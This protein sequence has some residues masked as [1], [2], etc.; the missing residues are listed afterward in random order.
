M[1][2]LRVLQAEGIDCEPSLLGCYIS[3]NSVLQDIITP[4]T[5]DHC[6][7]IPHEGTI[8]ITM[9]TM[10]EDS[11]IIGSVVFPL[12]ILTHEQFWLPLSGD[13]PLAFLAEMPDLPRIQ[14]CI[15]SYEHS[16]ELSP[17]SNTITVS[18]EENDWPRLR[19]QLKM[20]SFSLQ[21]ITAELRATKDTLKSEHSTRQVLEH[22]LHETQSE[23]SQ[24]V[25]QA[26]GREKSMLRL[27]EQK[28][29]EIAENINQTLKLQG[30]LDRLLEDKRHVEEKLACLQTVASNDEGELLRE[31]VVQLKYQLAQEDKRREELQEM[32]MQIGKE[33][34]ETEGQE[35][36][37]NEHKLIK[38]EQE[39]LRAKNCIQAL[40]GELE[41]VRAE[42]ERNRFEQS[43]AMLEIV[44]ITGEKVELH[45]DLQSRIEEIEGL[46][47][48]R[49][50]LQEDLSEK[51]EEFTNSEAKN[52]ELTTKVE[53]LS[54][55]LGAVKDHNSSLAEDLSAERQTNEK[56]LEKLQ[57]EKLYSERLNEQ[58]I[59]ARIQYEKLEEASKGPALESLVETCL[60]GLKKETAVT[61]TEGKFFFEGTQ[62]FLMKRNEYMV[63]VKTY[64]GA[65]PLA[66]YISCP[67][68]PSLKKRVSQDVRA[69]NEENTSFSS[70]YSIDKE[71]SFLFLE[72]KTESST[73]KQPIAAKIATKNTIKV[74]LRDKNS[75]PG[76]LS[77]ERRRPFK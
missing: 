28:D 43:Q 34:R 35:K 3:H 27:L 50:S 16:C 22:K 75:R 23:Y 74:P 68:T 76:S 38:A 5:P 24:F 20:Q 15:E 66:E 9:K 18:D 56:L 70:Y 61:C 45:K 63:D 67:R 19:L 53:D 30:Y 69:E 1:S 31:Q 11:Q 49:T 33:W 46:R 29:L 8:K 2:S 51:T 62:I 58:I 71:K 44:R 41:N 48:E 14:V 47:M 64:T 60:R 4:L 25:V 12:E 17:E 21:E 52:M 7:S 6:V 54:G 77:V 40:Q 39:V 42:D 59:Q 26:Q 65:I 37:N 72:K 36:M 55:E 10:C 57:Q 32:L 73:K 13:E